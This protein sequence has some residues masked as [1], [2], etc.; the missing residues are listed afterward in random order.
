MKVLE[1]KNISKKI[2]DKK[3]ID[4]VSFE[5]NSSSIIGLVGNNG[6]GK[7]SILKAITGLYRI[8]SGSIKICGIDAI[9]DS[10]DTLKHIGASVEE[11]CFYEFLNGYEN[12]IIYSNSSNVDKIIDFIG[13]RDTIYKKVSTYSLGMK[14]RL[15]LGIA[16]VNNPDII[17]LDE[18]TNGLDPKGIIELRNKLLS[19]K[20]NG[21]SVLICS[22]N[23]SELEKICDEILFIKD[24]K[25]IDKVLP[26]K[27][28]DSLES[29]Y[30]KIE[31]EYE[32]KK[33][34]CW[35]KKDIQKE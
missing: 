35:I 27:I 14:Q 16:L 7:T 11:N 5:I 8:D 18:P 28:K 6:A 30:S 34:L 12:L 17:I 21:K 24:G 31:R 2:G 20:E 10:F 4:N 26:K 23:L 22:H 29:I 9:K 13:L 3:I 15:S 1:V 32:N 19:L 25:I 33:Y